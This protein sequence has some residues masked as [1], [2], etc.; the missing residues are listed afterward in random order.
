MQVSCPPG[1]EDAARAFYGAGLGLT[2]VD[3]PEPLRGRGGVWFRAY[4]AA[5]RVVAELHVGV[6]D[7]YV[8][9]RRAHPALLLYDAAALATVEARL[10][11]LGHVVD[12]AERTTFP[13]YE[14]VHARDP[15][16]NRIELLVVA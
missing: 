13:G 7:P 1:G 12:G 4:D 15:F 11:A 14:R 5:G 2:E 10:S 9:P 3:K 16:G 6:E 8:A